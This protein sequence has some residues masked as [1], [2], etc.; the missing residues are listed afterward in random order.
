[1]EN[2]KCP[3]C[4]KELFHNQGISKKNNKPYENYK[5][6]CGYILWVD[7]KPQPK[8]DE[9]GSYPKPLEQEKVDWDKIR[10]EKSQGMDEG[11][12]RN[13]AVDLAIAMYNKGEI[14][15]K[16]LKTEIGLWF[17]F[18][19]ELKSNGQKDL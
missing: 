15:S 16:D 11:A 4:G 5:C 8:T 2:T 13:K 3:K 6:V 14:T 17:E 19:K 18:L 1:M 12:S 10:K 9:F 7:A